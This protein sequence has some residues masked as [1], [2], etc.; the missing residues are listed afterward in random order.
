LEVWLWGLLGREQLQV[1]G[2]MTGVGFKAEDLAS[3]RAASYSLAFIGSP[4][5]IR[6]LVRMVLLT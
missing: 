2:R 6:R 4:C 5:K 3:D 1:M